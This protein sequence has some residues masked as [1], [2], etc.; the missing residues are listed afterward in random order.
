MGAKLRNRISLSSPQSL[1]ML[2]FATG[3]NTAIDQ[4]LHVL[5]FVTGVNTAIDTITNFNY[6]K[7]A[8]NCYSSV[9]AI[10][11]SVLEAWLVTYFQ[12]PR[13]PRAQC[14]PSASLV[15]SLGMALLDVDS[16]WS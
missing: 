11:T 12:P 13:N 3:V 14:E 1:H 9:L 6:T 16:Q 15:T 4:S 5:G 7:C 8:R 2:G 10:V